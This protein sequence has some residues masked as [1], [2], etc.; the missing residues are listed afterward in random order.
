[1]KLAVII[2]MA[3]SGQRFKDA[4][5]RD[6][7]PFIKINGRFMVDLTIKPYPKSLKK[8]FIICR[9]HLTAAQIAYLKKLDNSE[10]IE[11]SPHKNGPSFSI[12]AAKNSLPKDY[13]Y[14]VSYADMFWTWD[15]EEVKKHL[16]YSGIVFTRTGWHPHLFRDNFSAFCLPKADNP[17]L[18]A[19]IK[20]KGSFTKDHLNEPLSMGAY[21]FKHAEEMFAAIQKQISGNKRAAGEFYPSELFNELSAKG[22]D[23]YLQEVDFYVHFGVPAQLEDYN[24]WSTV[25]TRKNQ[26]SQ[27]KTI[28]IMGGLGKR[29][30][31]I[32]ETPKAL[33]DID[34]YPMFE[35]VLKEFGSDD[36]TIVTT[37]SIA[38][39]LPKPKIKYSL[40]N[41]G[42]ST[43]SQ[44]ETMQKTAAE[45]KRQ[46]NFFLISCDAFGIIKPGQLKK[47]INTNR[48]DTIIFTFTPT[49]LQK[50]LAGQHSH[51]SLT[52][53]RVTAVHI[54]SKSKPDDRGLAGF[55]YFSKGAVFEELDKIPKD[56]ENELI[57]DHFLKHLV[58]SG[59]KI[60]G[61]N[62][63]Y[64]VHLGTVPEFL[65]YKF[66]SRYAKQ[67]P[68]YGR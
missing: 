31:A 14:F 58:D 5:Y 66:W 25:V 2:P 9:Q 23:V 28:C 8:F 48:P 40:I 60:Y 55:F 29:M 7:K 51:V 45:I 20:E 53:D 61:F 21:Y 65:E 22:R 39:R 12:H 10:V 62:L 1:M 34:G 42:P 54:K 37:K 44:I 50:K 36:N 24:F 19:Q 47:F 6:Y 57:A 16:N 33:I 17:K 59:K 56:S 26:S 64:Y 43:G 27:I 68:A 35:F 15:F 41:I 52:G 11:I 32:S 67:L 63:D 38:F 4:G 18:L 13:S 49:L 46:D 3:G 30:E